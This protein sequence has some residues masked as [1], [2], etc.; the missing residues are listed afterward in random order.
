MC[1]RVCLLRSCCTAV[2]INYFLWLS[3]LPATRNWCSLGASFGG[4][5][6]MSRGLPNS[7]SAQ[8]QQPFSCPFS[9]RPYTSLRKAFAL[10][11]GWLLV[12]HFPD[13]SI[14]GCRYLGDCVVLSYP[15]Y[16]MSSYP[17]WPGIWIPDRGREWLLL[18]GREWLLLCL[19]YFWLLPLGNGYWDLF[20]GRVNIVT[21]WC[22]I[23]VTGEWI[24]GFIPW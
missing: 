22:L 24:S 16:I 18:C 20:P 23:V 21:N 12:L 9:H 4:S 2:K 5:F 19:M 11:S 6:G 17:A 8:T 3:E 14:L 10:N 7:P 13:R 1:V 15:V